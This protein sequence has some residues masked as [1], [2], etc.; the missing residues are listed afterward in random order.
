M[1]VTCPSGGVSHVRSWHQQPK[2]P[3]GCTAFFIWATGPRPTD[4]MSNSPKIP[5]GHYSGI[6]PPKAG[7]GT[8]EVQWCTGAGNLG[9]SVL[10]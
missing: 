1:A 6:F 5:P 2:V 8:G 10:V 3:L 7:S 4:P 9:S